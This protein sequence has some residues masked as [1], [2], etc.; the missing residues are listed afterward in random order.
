[1]GGLTLDHRGMNFPRYAHLLADYVA[2]IA[3]F[4]LVSSKQKGPRPEER[5]SGE[6]IRQQGDHVSA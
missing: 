2:I 6:F 1:V 5:C 4:R 3:V